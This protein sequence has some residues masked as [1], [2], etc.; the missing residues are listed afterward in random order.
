MIISTMFDSG[1][2]WS[3]FTT[4][5][6][7]MRRDDTAGTS[8]IDIEPEKSKKNAID[9]HRKMMMMTLQEE[10]ILVLAPSNTSRTHTHA[11]T[12]AM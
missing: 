1:M 3:H 4:R 11:R 7:E 8:P 5:L 2:S 12:A 9:M 6:A 10:M